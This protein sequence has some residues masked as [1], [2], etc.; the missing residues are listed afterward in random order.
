[1]I[2]RQNRV[3]E[4]MMRIREV[5]IAQQHAIAEQRS[6]EEASKAHPTDYGDDHGPYQE[7]TEGGG[8]FAGPDPKK[9]RGVSEAVLL[10][11]SEL[12]H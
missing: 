3:L 4:S 8:G 7:K 6:R 12:F 5:V 10:L 11:C 1:M 2:R 9:R